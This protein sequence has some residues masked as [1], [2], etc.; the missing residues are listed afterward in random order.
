ML[1]AE[2]Q[3]GE[4]IRSV[5]SYSKFPTGCAGGRSLQSIALV[6]WNSEHPSSKQLLMKTALVHLS[7]HSRITGTKEQLKFVFSQF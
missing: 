2:H 7:C 5:I 6:W 1:V 3:A 4:E